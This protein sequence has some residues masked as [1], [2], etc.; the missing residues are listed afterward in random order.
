MQGTMSDLFTWA[1]TAEREAQT[2]YLG[3]AERFAHEPQVADFWREMAE[4]ERLHI[5]G[6]QQIFESLTPQQQET[7]ADPDTL[8]KAHELSQ[9]SASK[10]LQGIKTLEDAYELAHEL[11]YSEVNTVFEFILTEFVGDET[12]R[13]FVITQLREHM[14]RLLNSPTILYNSGWR[15]SVEAQDV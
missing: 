15:R 4:E 6:L 2:L 9:F 12:R 7:P 10:A 5:E 13:S 3:L 14:A 8:W 1:I 11:E